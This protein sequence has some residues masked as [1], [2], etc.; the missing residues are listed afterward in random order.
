MSTWMVQTCQVPHAGAQLPL[1]PADGAHV[2]LVSEEF[3]STPLAVRRNAWRKCVT[4]KWVWRIINKGYR[5]QFAITPPQFRGI[6]FSKA[7]GESACVLQEEISSLMKKGAIRIVPPE[8]SMYGFWY[9][10]VPKKGGGL[11]PILDLRTLNRHLRKFKFRM[12]TH[13]VLLRFVRRGDWFTSVN[14]QDAYF[15]IPIYPPHRK[16]LRF[17]FQGVTYEHLVLLFG[18]SLSLWVFVKCTEATVAPL[19][20]KGIRLA[21][22]IDDWLLAAQSEQEARQHTRL[23][24]EHLSALGFQFSHLYMRGFQRWVASLRLNQLRH[25]HR[26]VLVS[27]DCALALYQW[28]QPAFLTRGIPMGTILV[29]K[30]VTSDASLSGWGATHEGRSVNGVWDPHLRSA[31]INYLELLAVF[32]ALKLFLPY[33]AGHHVLV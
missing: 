17:A 5:L 14:V 8:E 32:L 18:L 19:R 26:R 16:F 21:T 27:I 2:P 12:L 20:R 4:S 6:L 13:T 24:T 3:P 23:L 1:T 28:R 15:H 22:Y 29:R 31:H 25:G 9:F 11:R 33:L 30:V 10:L 7:L